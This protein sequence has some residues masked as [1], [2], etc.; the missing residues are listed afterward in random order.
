VSALEAV[1]LP[2]FARG[3]KRQRVVDPEARKTVIKDV[4]KMT[5]WERRALGWAGQR[6]AGRRRLWRGRRRAPL[7]LDVLKRVTGAGAIVDDPDQA[8]DPKETEMPDPALAE[9]DDRGVAA[10]RE[11]AHLRVAVPGSGAAARAEGDHAGR[12]LARHAAGGL[13]AAREEG[14]GALPGDR[15]PARRKRSRSGQ[16][17]YKTPECARN[18]SRR[19]LLSA[20]T[21]ASPWSTTATPSGQVMGLA[22]L[23]HAVFGQQAAIDR[24]VAR[25]AKTPR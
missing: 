6:V 4:D 22:V 23:K 13:D 3:S 25:C 17:D 8:R 16:R 10:H 18:P 20:G 21:D 9:A 19:A 15:V 12:V 24:R 14:R 1:V 5:G 2:L 7:Q 11:A